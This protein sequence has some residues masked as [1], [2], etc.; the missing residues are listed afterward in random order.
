MWIQ[1]AGRRLQLLVRVVILIGAWTGCAEAEDVTWRIAGTIDSTLRLD[2]G[3]SE[4]IA[5][6]FDGSITLPNEPWKIGHF[7]AD[8]ESNVPLFVNIQTRGNGEQLSL[9]VWVSQFEQ[10]QP[11]CDRFSSSAAVGT[12]VEAEG[13]LMVTGESSLSVESEAC[14]GVISLNLS[15]QASATTVELP[16]VIGE[17]VDVTGKPRVITNGVRS[18]RSIGDPI[19]FGDSIET[20]SSSSIKIYFVD[21]SSL[22]VS[23]NANVVLD[24][25]FYDVTGEK[26]SANYSLVRGLFVYVSGLISKSG[27]DVYIET[28]ATG[29]GIRGTR[30]TVEYQESDGIGSTKVTVEDGVVE[31]NSRDGESGQVVE[32]GE[33]ATLELPVTENDKEPLQFL[34]AENESLELLL[35]GQAGQVVTISRSDDL[36]DWTDWR[37]VT[38]GVSPWT[39]G[40]IDIA[41]STRGFFRARITTPTDK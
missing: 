40:E 7:Q 24:E 3:E 15:F 18:Q 23:E 30:F 13:L 16:P 28:R 32:A 11:G 5:T 34:V 31:L 35:S 41:S 26:D 37:T 6:G 39:S 9:A 33:T 22:H 14:G 27:G 29:I 12:V 4:P 2:S 38:L 19:Y 17:V 20:D 21:E 8:I 10:Q 1:R 25:Y 36:I